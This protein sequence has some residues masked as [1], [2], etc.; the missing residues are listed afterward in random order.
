MRKLIN[1]EIMKVKRGK[2]GYNF[3]AINRN[4]RL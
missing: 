2:D 1:N 3:G 4:H